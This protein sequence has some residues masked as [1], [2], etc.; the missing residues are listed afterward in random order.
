MGKPALALHRGFFKILGGV[1]LCVSLGRAVVTGVSLGFLGRNDLQFLDQQYYDRN[2]IYSS[3]AH[4]LDG[5]FGWEA[6]A[7][8]EHFPATGR[9]IVLG[10]G[11]GREV[12]ALEKLGFEVVGYECHPKLLKAG[13]RLLR[14]GRYSAELQ[15]MERDQC[16]QLPE[17]IAGI[18]IGWG[19]YMLIQGRDRR[20]KLLRDLRSHVSPGSPML[21]SFFARGAEGWRY[22]VAQRVAQPF[23]SM[24]GREMV[25]EGDYLAPNWVH[26]FTEEDVQVELEAAGWE[27]LTYRK[28]PYGNAVARAC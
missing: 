13:V 10:A 1:E 19:A 9:L 27:L 26:F 3:N 17:D 7:V 21:L 5:L 12:I 28:S 8:A 6:R 11:G 18:I 23:R 14:E 4:N 24:L 22:R 20:I 15:A 25:E 2:G 16:P